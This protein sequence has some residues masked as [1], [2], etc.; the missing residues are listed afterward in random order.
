MSEY[1][2]KRAAEVRTEEARYLATVPA[3]RALREALAELP[4]TDNDA[5]LAA[6]RPMLEDYSWLADMTSRWTRVAAANSAFIF[7]IQTAGQFG[8]ADAF[9]S[10]ILYS[11][12]R[13]IIAIETLDDAVL[14][15]FRSDSDGREAEIE[16]PGRHVA[17]RVCGNGRLTIDLYETDPLTDDTDLAR[18]LPV[19]NL[20]TKVIDEESGVFEMD[21]RRQ[22][23]RIVAATGN[24]VF[25]VLSVVGSSLQCRVRVGCAGGDIRKVEANEVRYNKLRVLLTLLDMIDA[26]G[27]EAVLRDFVAHPTFFVRYHALRELAVLTGAGSEDAIVRAL[28]AETNPMMQRSLGALRD[29]VRRASHDQDE[30]HAH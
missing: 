2:F 30:A 13:A 25:L 20:G 5:I 1:D 9:D 16:F 29:A 4:P 14:R 24:P 23:F 8:A 10:G 7:P 26:E 6:T 22:A 3:L 15:K 27:R 28:D 11:D 17:L 18:P 21:G 12:T 19:R